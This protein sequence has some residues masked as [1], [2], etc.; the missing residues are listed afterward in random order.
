[1]ILA[2]TAVAV[3]SLLGPGSSSAGPSHFRN[4][5]PGGAGF[6]PLFRGIGDPLPGVA[7][8]NGDVSNFNDGLLNFQETETLKPASNPSG[9]PGQLGPLFNNN[10]CA[11]CHSNPARG[12]GAL[13]LM[14]QRLSTGGPPVRIFAVDHMLSGPPEQQDALGTIFPYGTISAPLGAQIGMPDNVPSVCQQEEIARGFS[15]DLPIC[16]AG[17]ANDTGLTGTPTCVAHRQSLPLFGDGLVEAT[18]DATFQALA[19]G[20][21]AAVRGTVRMV[22]DSA[23]FD[24]PASEVSSITL[25]ALGT[26][27][28]ARFGWKDDFSTLVGFSADAQFDLRDRRATVRHRAADRRRSGRFSGL[29]RPLGHR[30]F[31]GFHAQSATAA[32]G[33]RECG[34]GYR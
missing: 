12:G 30:P 17:G 1:L 9:P 19:A 21:P 3:V 7:K 16:I 5:K 29:E 4:A 31:H 20:E 6:A 32:R 15:P 18:S 33:G 34:R 28:V 13:D 2:V 26:A 23:N 14:E 10:S 24:G 27:H 8:S 25:A 22:A 11:A